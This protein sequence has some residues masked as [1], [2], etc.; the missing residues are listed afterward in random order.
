MRITEIWR[1]PV[2][3]MAGEQ[4]QDARVGPGG[5]DGDRRWAVVDVESG[6]SLSAK[7][8]PELLNCRAWT[9]D[10][11]TMICL[12]D[13]SEYAAGSREVARGL[14]DLLGR[15]VT[16]RSA[17]N[18]ETIQH[19]FPTAI[20]DGEG[21]PF[22]WEPGTS[23]FFDCSPFH[24]LTTASVRA[25]QQ[26]LPD[27]IIHPVRFRPNF[28]VEANDVGFIENSWVEGKISLGSL[29]FQVYDHMRRCV[30]VTRHQG[31][32]PLDTRV[33]R[34][35]LKKNDGNAGVALKTSGSGTLRCGDKAGIPG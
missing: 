3:S 5:I 14:C 25:F 1:Y 8:Y 17:S 23:S 4:L 12:P 29:Q 31:D 30:M 2:K 33:I 35:I 26:L 19:E 15:D 13:G 28:L 10:N 32:L 16:T 7:R 20:T 9:V 11:T 22:L 34:T 21:E 27:S 24:L 18:V 6:V